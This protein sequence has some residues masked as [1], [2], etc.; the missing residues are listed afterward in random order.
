LNHH[1][2]RLAL[3]ASTLAISG[4]H[5]RT[6]YEC[7]LL[8][9]ELDASA[10]TAGINRQGDIVGMSAADGLSAIWWT[11]DGQFRAA[12]GMSTARDLNDDGT[13]VGTAQDGMLSRAALWHD[14]ALQLLPS[15]TKEPS[16]GQANAINRRG[17]VVGIGRVRGNGQDHAV[18][19][20]HGR[21]IDL[22]ALGRHQDQKATFSFATDINNAGQVVGF[23]DVSPG[24]GLRHAVRWDNPSTLVDLGTLPGGAGS[25]ALA[26]NR[27]GLTVGFSEFGP[28]TDYHA[29]AWDEN[30][31]HD[32]G[33]LPGHARSSAYAVS[34]HGVAVGESRPTGGFP[35]QAAVWFNQT[36]PPKTL[37]S[38]AARTPRAAPTSSCAAPASTPPESSP[39]T[40]RRPMRMATATGEPSA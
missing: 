31:V 15:L 39:P 34:D 37:D 6:V 26:I 18:L 2:T 35:I 19:W 16:D 5:A 8:S 36:E 29:T 12:Q 24:V 20:R 3:L 22:G 13:I 40:A 14:G 33:T 32:L 17:E 1:S 9:P 38:L 7:T 23:S 4:A 21:V 28:G 25:I 10:R 27:H 30:G 11:A